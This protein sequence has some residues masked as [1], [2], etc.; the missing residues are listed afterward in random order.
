M[1]EEKLE[2]NVTYNDQVSKYNVSSSG[3]NE[4]LPGC[5][6]KDGAISQAI[7]PLN[8]SDYHKRLNEKLNLDQVNSANTMDQLLLQRQALS[9]KMH[10]LH[11]RF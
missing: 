11:V 6:S 8:N 9:E 4:V 2:L 1:E 3:L 10:T 7:K 5:K